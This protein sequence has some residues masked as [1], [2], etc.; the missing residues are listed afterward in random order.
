MRSSFPEPPWAVKI[1]GIKSAAES[2]GDAPMAT[3]TAEA[4]AAQ[5]Q[6]VEL[7][8]LGD[9]IAEL[10]AHVSAATARLLDLIREFDAR[11]GWG[12]GFRSCAEWLTWRIGLA[13]NAAREHGRVARA[14][15][16]LP[17]LATALAT[18]ELSYSKVRALTRVA[19]PDTEERLLKVGKAATAAHVERIIRAWRYVDRKAEIRE[20]AERHRAR[21]VHVYQDEDGMVI[22]RG[23]L[24]PE[25]G[26]VL[27]QALAAAREKVY[28]PDV[29]AGTWTVSI[30]NEA[31]TWSQV[32]AD[33]LGLIAETAL[34]H[35]MEAGSASERYQVV[36]HVDAAVL[37]N[38]DAPGQGS[39]KVR[40]FPR[41]RR[42]AWRATRAAW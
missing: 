29:P 2:E 8:R 28:Q 3:S 30:G 12:N 11:G 7:R 14:L 41:K 32:Q 38:A 15:A 21:A 16:S 9:E 13:P 10:A 22:V 31:P 33:A 26:A 37:E 35:G 36:V 4:E 39:S 23:R 17:R 34:H 5:E 24:E 6:E 1:E 27:M 42:S 18:G 20:T 19:N 40:A 25:A